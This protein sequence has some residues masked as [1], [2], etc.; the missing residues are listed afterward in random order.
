MTLY[1]DIKS[2]RFLNKLDFTAPSAV[3][4]DYIS[5]YDNFNG[6]NTAHKFADEKVEFINKKGFCVYMLSG[7]VDIVVDGEAHQLRPKTVSYVA[8]HSIVNLTGASPD[9]RFFVYSISPELLHDVYADIGMTF[10]MPSKDKRFAQKVLSAEDFQYRLTLYK[11]Q[12]RDLSNTLPELRRYVVQAYQCLL[13]VNDIELFEPVIHDT[14]KAMSRQHTLFREFVDLLGQHSQRE[15][16]VQYY[17]KQLGITPKYLSALCI[18]YSGK[19]AS[20]WIDDYVI[21][22]IRYYMQENRFTIKEISELM[23]FPSQSFFG[24]YFK[25]VTGMSPRAYMREM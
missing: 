2:P 3:V 20:S 4:D 25:R 7:L 18:E 21:A 24:R 16:E 5:L 17:A 11:E 13:H 6:G 14:E 9:S 15:R 22:R 12:V 1:H 19:N 10:K 8:P 23:H